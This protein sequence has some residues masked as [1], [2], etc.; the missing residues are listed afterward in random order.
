MIPSFLDDNQSART[1]AAS[2]THAAATAVD[3]PSDPKANYAIVIKNISD[4]KAIISRRQGPSGTSWAV[5]EVN[6]TNK[7]FRYIGEGDT[8]NEAMANLHTRD[9]MSPVIPGSISYYIV[10]AACK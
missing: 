1:I 9:D 8:L 6:C 4:F 7:S 2:T 3:V 10:N 5:R